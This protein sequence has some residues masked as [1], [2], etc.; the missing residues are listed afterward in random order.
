MS[1]YKKIDI[2][3]HN[4]LNETLNF[5]R[6]VKDD[7]LAFTPDILEYANE[8]HFINFFLDFLV[9]NEEF[10]FYIREDNKYYLN[11]FINENKLILDTIYNHVFNYFMYILK[12]IIG[13]GNAKQKL[14]TFSKL[15]F[16]YWCFTLSYT[17]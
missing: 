3:Y 6:Y 2:F 12:K 5:W 17:Y 15:Y 7:R 14:S 4:Y 11:S 10:N 9:K 8:T 13:N 1:D 16:Y